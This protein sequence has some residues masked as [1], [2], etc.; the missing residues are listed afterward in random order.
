[1]TAKEFDLALMLVEDMTDTWNPDQYKDTYR[2]DLM[3]R[4]QEKVK[5]GQTHSLTEPAREKP[6]RRSAEIIDL[7]TLLKRSLEAKTRPAAKTERKPATRRRVRR[8][9][10]RRRA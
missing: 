3:R 4:I 2:E 5:K 8:P 1:M 7:T 6:A 10:A 9:A